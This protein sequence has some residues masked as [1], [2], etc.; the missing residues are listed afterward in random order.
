M[1]ATPPRDA[2]SGAWA[3]T[4]GRG[5][6]R[7]MTEPRDGA[8]HDR[9]L[10]D[11]RPVSR[12]HAVNVSCPTC[13]AA[14]AVVSGAPVACPGCAQFLV[15][16]R[17]PAPPPPVTGVGAFALGALGGLGLI[18]LGIVGYKVAQAVTDEDFGTVEFPARFRRELIAAHIARDGRRCP[19]CRRHVR[20]RDLAVD[21]VVALANGGRTSRANARVL[22]RACNSRKGARQTFTDYIA[23]RSIRSR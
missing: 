21:H 14:L 20:R 7:G 2:P 17:V 5:V 8:G 16:A 4:L 3:S 23:G 6:V 12:V 11:N 15:L 9:R 10:L 18:A 19:R 22:C 1:A 13:G